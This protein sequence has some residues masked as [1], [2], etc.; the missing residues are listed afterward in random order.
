M[1]KTKMT[2]GAKIAIAIGCCVIILGIAA[3]GIQRATSKSPGGDQTV[4]DYRS[5][6]AF[7]SGTED[8]L[9][10]GQIEQNYQSEAASQSDAQAAILGK[11]FTV[12]ADE[13]ARVTEVQMLIDEESAAEIA[14]NILIEK[15][16]LYYQAQEAG[17]VVT[18]EYLDELIAEQIQIFESIS[19]KEYE[20]F[21][22]GIGMTNE[23]YWLSQKDELRMTESIAAWKQLKRDEFMDEHSYGENPPENLDKLWEAHCEELIADM[24]RQEDVRIVE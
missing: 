7:Q 15:Y 20:A 23:E 5:E 12:S 3:F 24:I 2:R 17:V 10:W 8:A 14:Q 6:E 21:L 19:D 13:L 9:A 4:Q 1:N 18:D 22:D 11:H 16:T